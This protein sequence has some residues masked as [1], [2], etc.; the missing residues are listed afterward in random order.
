MIQ[1]IQSFWLLLAGAA[2]FLSLRLSFFSGNS[3]GTNNS[4]L[5]KHFTASSNLIILIL[6]VILGL[7]VVVAIFLLKTENYNCG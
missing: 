5:F 3:T 4:S 6:T 1:R 2:A 7:M